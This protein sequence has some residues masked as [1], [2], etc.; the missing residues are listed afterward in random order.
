MLR[1]TVM[2]FAIGIGLG[3]VLALVVGCDAPKKKRRPQP[4][5]PVYQTLPQQCPTGDCPYQTTDLRHAELNPALA[6]RVHNYK[7]GSCEYASLATVL[8]C[9]GEH[10]WAKWITR[11]YSGG[12]NIDGNLNVI[13]ERAG[14]KFAMTTTGDPEWLKWC[15]RTRRPAAIEYYGRHCVTF[16]SAVP[17]DSPNPRWAKLLDNNHPER[18]DYIE[19]DKFVHRWKHM[20]GGCAVAVIVPPQPPLPKF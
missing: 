7:G 14:F 16:I 15:S 6:C 8:N 10:A 5:P 17:Y 3:I 20:Y 18:Y 12:A 19:W 13:L 11:N 4:R 9:A 2:G 1:K